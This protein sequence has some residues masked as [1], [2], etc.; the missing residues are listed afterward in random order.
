MD[1]KLKQ[2]ID[3]TDFEALFKKENYAF[4]TS[5][6]YNVNIIG[7]RNLING[8]AHS[9]DF[10]DAI[11]LLYK[12]NG[13]WVKKVWE[14]TTD[15]GQKS[16]NSPSNS[17]GT[18]ILVPYQYRGVY[19]LDLHNGQYKALCQR[20]GKVAV[21]RDNN[22]DKRLDFDPRTITSGEF[23]INIHRGNANGTTQLVDG[24]S[25]GCQVF[26]NAS[27]F[28]EFIDILDKASAKYG[29]KFTYTLITSDILTR[30]VYL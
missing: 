26:K 7:V 24:W 2:L 6:D 28:N 27:D 12:V 30:C 5:G 22:K 21:Y 13:Q 8:T 25:A 20:L 19:K 23:G 29:N 11:I 18:A 14:I 3:L 4:F 16:L 9:N 10:N 1:S 17:N 15:P